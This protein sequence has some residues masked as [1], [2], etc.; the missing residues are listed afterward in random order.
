[1][2][3]EIS[4][5]N[6]CCAGSK[7]K[8]RLVDILDEEIETQTETWIKRPYRKRRLREITTEQRFQRLRDKEAAEKRIE[9]HEELKQYI[10]N[11]DTCINP[12]LFHAF[13]LNQKAL[14]VAI[15]LYHDTEIQGT[16]LRHYMS[17]GKD[18]RDV[19]KE[20]AVERTEELAINDKILDQIEK[21]TICDDSSGEPISVH[22]GVLRTMR[23]VDFGSHV[24]EWVTIIREE[25]KQAEK[26][27]LAEWK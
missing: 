23:A 4:T 16:L 3:E 26:E 14:R 12:M 13:C 11:M 24:R 6:L 20:R 8:A 7:V 22:L 2:V 18:I 19:E 17:L 27:K 1:M 15:A 10:S 5:A 25:L 9:K 21:F